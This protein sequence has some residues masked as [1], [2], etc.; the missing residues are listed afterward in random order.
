MEE[1]LQELQE[2]LYHEIP[3]TR[4]IG[5]TVKEYTDGALSL[6]APLVQNINHKQTAFAGSLNAVATLAGW[7]E[8]WL[9]LR[10]LGI[11]GKIVIQDSNTDYRKPVDNDFI[12]TC[13]R[14]TAQ[15]VEKLAQ[16]LRKKGRARLELQVAVYS[17]NI[18]AVLFTG[19]YVIFRV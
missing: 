14:P 10:E 3:L 1:L 6:L 4:F 12:A 2:T 11:A 7:G 13:Q 5:I 19:R 8:C 15:E 9:L 17:G 16:A 18:L